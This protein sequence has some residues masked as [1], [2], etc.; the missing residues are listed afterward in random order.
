MLKKVCDKCGKNAECFD[1]CW[2][3]DNKIFVCPD[4]DEKLEVKVTDLENT[5]LA[6]SFEQELREHNQA[7][8]DWWLNANRIGGEK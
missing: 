1:G 6:K 2:A 8:Y 7:K 4:Q 5:E 3:K